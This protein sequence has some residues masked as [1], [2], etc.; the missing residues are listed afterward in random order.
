MKRVLI[1]FLIMPCAWSFAFAQMTYMRGGNMAA[2]RAPKIIDTAILQV[3]YRA[4]S[5]ID[6]LAPD[7]VAQDDMILQIGKNRSS[8]FFTDTRV[9]DSIMQANVSRMQAAAASGSAPVF[10]QSQSVMQGGPAGSGNQSIVFKNWPAGSVTVTD[11]VMMDSYVYTEPANEIRWEILPDTDVILSYTCQK[12]VT[13]FRGRVYEAWFAPDIPINEGPWKFGGLPGLILKVSDTRQH[14]VFECIALEQT[15][16]Q[17]EYADLDYLKT[18]RRDLARV[19][20]KFHEDPMAAVESMRASAPTG[21]NVRMTVRSSD[22]SSMDENEMR[23]RLR[24]RAYN[25]IELDY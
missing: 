10:V 2:Q 8:K 3:V 13:T 23:N 22:G 1:T 17:M 19:K 20:R 14:Y 4:Y 11:R 7:R 24:N 12:A 15:P 21:A 18:N 16:T 5:V 25:P 9:R 6:S